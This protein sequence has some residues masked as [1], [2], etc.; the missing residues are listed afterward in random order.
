MK[1]SLIAIAALAAVSA[2]SAQSSVTLFG[3]IDVGY[4]SHSTTSRD[5]TVFTKSSGI[6]D[7]GQAGSRIGFRGTEDLGGGLKA[8]F[9]I[10]NGI[11]PTSGNVFSQRAA[12]GAHQQTGL[13]GGAFSTST[14]RQS[15]VGLSSGMG[16][17]DVGFQYTNAYQLSSLSGYHL[18]TELVGTGGGHL[19]GMGNVGGSR[20]DGITYTSP[21][22]SGMTVVA[23]YGSSGA[24]LQSFTANANAN[25]ATGL[26]TDKNDRTGL[27]LKYAQGPLSAA[28]AYTTMRTSTIAGGAASTLP[29]ATTNAFGVITTAGTTAIL[30]QGRTPSLTQLAG[31]Y[32]LGV[33]KI[34]GSYSTG[35]NGGTT[36]S[37]ANTTVRGYSISVNAPMGALTP[38][39]AVTKESNKNDVTGV[40]S[41]DIAG[42]QLGV[43]Y[44]LSKRT[45]AYA[46]YANET[47]NAVTTAAGATYKNNKTIAGVAHSF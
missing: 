3:V 29:G 33:A 32:D 45:T 25:G 5:G 34:G 47:D 7:G 28:F 16:T 4:G 8:N 11:S 17:L 41:R 14:N 22:F 46:M 39:L 42:T 40:N 23:Q 21:S 31:S 13:T 18:G 36:T 2:A 26:T 10:E 30:G 44:A 37:T 12:A 9:V 20:A 6:N 24:N 35:K 38:Y 19:A 27:M 15:Y 1:K 43:R